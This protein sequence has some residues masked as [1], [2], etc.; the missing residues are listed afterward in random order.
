MCEDTK[1]IKIKGDTYN[2]LE[3]KFNCAKCSAETR[4]I[5]NEEGN[6]LCYSCWQETMGKYQRPHGKRYSAA[7]PLEYVEE[8]LEIPGRLL[9]IQVNHQNKTVEVISEVDEAPEES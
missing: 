2:Y 9:S 8:R 4:G 3:Y 5:R 6:I 7:F 1:I